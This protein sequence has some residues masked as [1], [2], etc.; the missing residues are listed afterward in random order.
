MHHVSRTGLYQRVLFVSLFDFCLLLSLSVMNTFVSLDLCLIILF[1]KLYGLVSSFDGIQTFLGYF[2][3]NTA[4]EISVSVNKK[5][6]RN[7]VKTKTI[8]L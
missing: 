7:E 3:V 2:K 5:K 6:K 1:Q 8:T 4:N